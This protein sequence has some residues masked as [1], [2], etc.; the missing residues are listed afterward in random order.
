MTAQRRD[1]LRQV[2]AES[3]VA[4]LIVT[5][6]PNVRYL[7]GF[8]GSNGVL[9]VS[10]E[11]AQDDVL[12]TDG[13]YVT[14]A[15]AQS[16]DLPLVVDRAT[17][18]A[19]ARSLAN[20]GVVDVEV[21]SSITAEQQAQLGAHL[22]RVIVGEGRIEALRVVKDERELA[23]LAEAG[24]VTAEAFDLMIGEVR[25]GWTEIQ[26]ARRLEQLFGELGAEDRAF[27]TIVASGPN[28]A[29]PHHEPGRRALETGDLVVI[30]FGARIDGYHADMTRTAVVGQPRPWQVD[31]HA[32][33]LEAQTVARHAAW[34]GAALVDIDGA[35]RDCLAA[36]ELGEAFVHGL[37]HG[38]G[39]EIHEAPMI[40]QRSIGSIAASTP[41]TVEPGAYLPG[42]GGVRIEDSLVVTPHGPRVLT[43]ADRGLWPI[44]D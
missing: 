12:A 11:D 28:S 27:P 39:L 1:R 41:I 44:G 38:I 43:E 31:L 29:V 17:L 30:D 15:G 32:S 9:F 26:V 5:H 42:R 40:N 19:L 14:Q 18:D 33:V 20:H 34:P 8:S 10:A 35:A 7:S 13:R 24:R 6:L 3:D 22:R 16:P 25:P 21:E 23:A 2:L 4:G 37:G 36:A